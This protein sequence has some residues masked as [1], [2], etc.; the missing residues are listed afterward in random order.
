MLVWRFLAW[1]ALKNNAAIKGRY[2]IQSNKDVSK[3]DS[4]KENDYRQSYEYWMKQTA[5]RP[6][7]LGVSDIGG[8]GLTEILYRH[9]EESRH[10]RRLV[11]FD[12][13]KTVLELGS[14]NGRWAI[15]LAPL[16]KHYEAV[17][18]SQPMLD[19]A[20]ARTA[21]LKLDNIT[22]CRATVQDYIPKT[23]FDIVYLSGITQ[24]LHDDDLLKLLER[25][26]RSLG[27]NATLIDRSTVH[28]R[29]RILTG[30]QDYFCIYRTYEEL[31]QLF[32]DAGFVLDCRQ[33]SYL[34]LNMPG[35]MRRLLSCRQCASIVSFTAP[36]SFHFLR[37]LA[38]VSRQFWGPTGEVVDFSHDFFIF[39]RSA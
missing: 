13:Q 25:L 11:S 37:A 19:I 4:S 24:Y 33:Q 36:F 3:G 6:E 32:K 21:L 7:L 17:D 1:K 18:F 27:P 12:R 20:R 22:F 15:A 39:H 8:C 23:S 14:G 38:K 34:F 30:Q 26:H 9:F 28:R 29:Q 10:L 31:E 16:V 35:I 5:E 2:M